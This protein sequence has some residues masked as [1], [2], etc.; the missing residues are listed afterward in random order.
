MPEKLP[1]KQK[2]AR[3]RSTSSTSSKAS[4]CSTSTN[5]VNS[6]LKQPSRLAQPN[7]TSDKL[8]NSSSTKHSHIR[9]PPATSKTLPTTKAKLASAPDPPQRTTSRL[10]SDRL[11]RQD[12][13]PE[14]PKKSTTKTSIFSRTN[15]ANTSNSTKAPPPKTSE[16]KEA[17]TLRNQNGLSE[18]HSRIKV[19]SRQKIAMTTDKTRGSTGIRS[20][21]TTKIRPPSFLPQKASTASG[22]AKSDIAP[23]I[24][25]LKYVSVSGRH[26]ASEMDHTR[27]APPPPPQ[28]SS[29]KM[30]KKLTD[31]KR[32][33]DASNTVQEKP[34]P[35]EPASFIPA[36]SPTQPPP[37]PER[38]TSTSSVPSL[39]EIAIPTSSNDILPQPILIPTATAVPLSTPSKLEPKLQPKSTSESNAKPTSEKKEKSKLASKLSKLSQMSPK[40]SRKPIKV[41]KSFI[42]QPEE[43]KPD[44]PK[45]EPKVEKEKLTKKSS[46]LSLFSPKV[47]KKS[48]KPTAASNKANFD[49]QLA[50]SDAIDKELIDVENETVSIQLTMEENNKPEITEEIINKCLIRPSSLHL[51]KDRN[52]SL[53][54]RI[55]I[56]D[57][58]NCEDLSDNKARIFVFASQ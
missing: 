29:T 4:N 45:V 11:T 20:I 2:Q 48:L 18:V 16:T 12:I 43:I 3:P 24:T 17:T 15:N 37:P 22:K 55:S 1:A 36:R 56:I 58:V 7:G 28:Q 5:P 49:P 26:A 51:E 50:T 13:P 31:T 25:K 35:I 21:E 47:P 44:E 57:L 8:S 6:R 34:T 54:S 14:L 40:F 42:S 38:T 10:S 53:S 19:H 39:D 9:K 23:A 27:P 32:E 46:S 52:P 41:A 33:S 30:V